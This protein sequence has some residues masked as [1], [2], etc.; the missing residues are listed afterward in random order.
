MFVLAEPKRQV[1]SCAPVR[2]RVV[3]HALYR[4]LAPMLD[5]GH[6]HHTYA[7]SPRRGVHRAVLAFQAAIRWQRRVRR[8]TCARSW[9]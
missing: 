9:A 1:I 5:A 4:E 6:V 3:H 7:C 8:S 2:D